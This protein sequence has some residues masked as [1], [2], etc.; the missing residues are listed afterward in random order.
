MNRA[1]SLRGGAD[2]Q[3]VWDSGK[4]WSHPLI[5]L[6]ASPN[7]METNRFG[8]V[9]GKKIGKAVKRNRAKRL[10][11]EAVRHRLSKITKGWDVMLIAR[12][13]AEQAEFKDID[14]AVEEVLRRARLV[15]SSR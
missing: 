14:A 10:I 6:R 2:F 9:V 11:R 3:R 8:I 13:E 1:F 7:G 4:S 5:V 12:A 15:D